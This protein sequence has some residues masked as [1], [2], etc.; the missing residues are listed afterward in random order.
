MLVVCHLVDRQYFVIMFFF[1]PS[2]FFVLLCLSKLLLNCSC[3]FLEKYEL[4]RHV[5]DIYES[6]VEKVVRSFTE[7]KVATR[8]CENRSQ[9][10][11]EPYSET[12]DKVKY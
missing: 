9:K 7:V 11:I 1:S 8:Q 6:V 12:Y 10:S 2:L 5:S 3:P 4:T